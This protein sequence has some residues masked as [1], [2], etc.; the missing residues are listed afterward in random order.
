MTYNTLT[1]LSFKLYKD[2][3]ININKQIILDILNEADYIYSYIVKSNLE[4]DKTVLIIKFT[5]SE[6]IKHNTVKS[7]SMFN[8][9]I[10]L[11]TNDI[12]LNKMIA[13]EQPRLSIV[14]QVY[15]SFI[16][17]IAKQQSDMW[18]LEYEDVYQMCALAIVKL[19]NKNYFL[20]K[21]IVEK[22]CRNDILCSLRKNINKPIIESL[23]QIIKKDTSTDDIRYYDVIEDE[24]SK[25]MYEHIAHNDLITKMFNEVKTIITNKYGER[26]FN[27]LF[28]DYTNGSTD[29]ISRTMMQK[30]KIYFKKRN[31]TYKSL[32]GEEYESQQ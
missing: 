28:R 11:L 22:T 2:N 16:T 14:F 32:Q 17:K 18:H 31:I 9:L 7:I 3:D 24:S 27:K 29:T 12:E 23:D 15:N 21:Y 26:K 25:Y 20:N 4:N 5:I 19:Y 30:V 1:T 8:K 6:N 13:F 10:E